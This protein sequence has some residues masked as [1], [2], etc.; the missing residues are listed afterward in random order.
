MNGYASRRNFNT[1]ILGDPGAASQNDAMF[2]GDLYFQAKVYFKSGRAPGHLLPSNQ[3]RSVGIHLQVNH[4]YASGFSPV[5]VVIAPI[6]KGTY[7]FFYFFFIATREQQYSTY[8]GYKTT[9]IIIFI[10]LRPLDLLQVQN[11]VFHLN[12]YRNKMNKNS[13]ENGN[14]TLLVVSTLLPVI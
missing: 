7:I 12:L 9:F 8:N 14:Q 3:F 5:L 6:S 1:L 13:L 4:V 2:S 11:F 10:Y